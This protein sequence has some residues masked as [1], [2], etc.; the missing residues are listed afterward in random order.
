MIAMGMG[1]DDE[2]GDNIGRAH[3]RSRIVIKE[4]VDEDNLT[5]IGGNL[6]G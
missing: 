4:R 3:R 2:I 1:Q 5:G 6:K